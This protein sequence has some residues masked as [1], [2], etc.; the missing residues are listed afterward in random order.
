MK[1]GDKPASRRTLREDNAGDGGMTAPLLSAVAV[2]VFPMSRT[3]KHAVLPHTGH[4][5]ALLLPS[6][7]NVI[8]VKP[9]IGRLPAARDG[10]PIFAA[11]GRWF[12]STRY[13]GHTSCNGR[14]T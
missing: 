10:F 1:V 4:D 12:V 11:V 5:T 8:L 14:T 3:Q 9:F 2:C 6:S 13:G 7:P